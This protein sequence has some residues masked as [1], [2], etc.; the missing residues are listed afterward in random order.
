M[1]VLVIVDHYL[2]GYKGG[3]P[4]RTIANLVDWL[5]DEFEFYILTRDRDLGDETAYPDIQVNTWTQVRKAHVYYATPDKLTTSG[6]KI[7]FHN[8]TFDA[9][10]V[11]S[12][13]S[14]L[15]IKVAYLYWLKRIDQ[16]T[17]LIAPRGEFHR[18]ALRIKRL[19]KRAY[20][21]LAKMLNWY[22]AVRWVASTQE[23]VETIKAIFPTATD[24]LIAP[25]LT[26]KTLPPL[27]ETRIPKTDETR[28]VFFSRISPKK[29]LD[30]ALRI[31]SKVKHPLTFDI[32][33]TLEDTAYWETCQQIISKLPA[34]VTVTYRG[35]LSPENVIPTLS[36]YHLFFFPT[37]G[38]NFGHVIWEALY[39]GLPVLISDQTPWHDLEESSAGWQVPLD[40]ESRF[41]EIIEQVIVL[42]DVTFQKMSILSNDYAKNSILD[43]HAL[44]ANRQLFLDTPNG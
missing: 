43:T 4:I 33:G 31:L 5:G 44:D 7:L 3:G 2:P 16:K 37:H 36:C 11:N 34:H 29:N 12:F 18:G 28:L 38:E 41:V 27:P 26:T 6:L 40:D 13:F 30:G 35:S 14:T 24:I 1:K 15:S 17:W 32:Y 42:D 23:E 25:N 19:K 9:L 10:Y 21:T 8:L 22:Q 20:L 39:A